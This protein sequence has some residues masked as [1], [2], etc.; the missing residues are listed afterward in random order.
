MQLFSLGLIDNL[1]E[2][3]D[4][5]RCGRYH[6]GPYERF[7]VNDPKTRI[8]HKAAVR[9]RVVHRAVYRLLYPFF[10]RTFTAD[11]FSCRI[12]KGTHRALERF[13]ALVRRQ[14]RNHT[15]TVWVLKAD[16]K[17]FFASID[18]AVLL[19]R[20]HEYVPDAGLMGLLSGIVDSFSTAQGT[21]LPLGNLTSQLF[22]NVYMNI[23]DQ[24]VKHE[25]K[26]RSYVRYADD[27]V[28]ISPDRTRLEYWLA[29]LGAFLSDRLKLRLHPD[30]LWIKTLASGVDFLGWVHFPHHRVLR[31]STRR[32]VLRATYR[33]HHPQALASYLGLLQHGSTHHLRDEV[34]NGAA[35]V[36]VA[37]RDH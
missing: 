15:R 6:H 18:H 27:F 19:A 33:E 14:S 22:C 2:L 12:G 8:I 37:H 25:L 4:E 30:K 26:A 36:E 32:R 31:T 11:S 24:F 5:L 21:G 16:V 34:L 10:D 28:L 23:F 1:T 20:L 3:A 13:T 7:I 9:D 35:F 17:K 29:Q